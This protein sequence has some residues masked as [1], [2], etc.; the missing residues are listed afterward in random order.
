[1]TKKAAAPKAK[2]RTSIWLAKDLRRQ[3]DNRAKQENRSLAS[4]IDTLL[5][6]GLGKPAKETVD[7]PAPI[8]G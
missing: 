8:F 1:M 2:T 4:T 6:K 5:R 7:A 3:L